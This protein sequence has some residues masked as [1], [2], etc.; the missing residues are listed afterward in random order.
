MPMKEQ[1]FDRGRFIQG[2]ILLLLAPVLVLLALAVFV[3]AANWAPQSSALKTDVWPPVVMPWGQATYN[4]TF[5]GQKN[6]AT[7]VQNKP[8]DMLFVVDVSSSMTPILK[9]MSDVAHDLARQLEA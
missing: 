3:L 7:P 4:I 8:V 2:L 5:T 9:Y 6:Q 1:V